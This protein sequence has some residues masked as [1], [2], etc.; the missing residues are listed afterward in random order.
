M[1]GVPRWVWI[2]GGLVLALVLLLWLAG[3]ALSCGFSQLEDATEEAGVAGAEHGQNGTLD[4]CVQGVVA[5]SE[6]CA[7]PLTCATSLASF[8]WG[9]AEAA[10]ADP[11]FCD[12][13]P[14]DEGEQAH[15]RWASET[16]T[17]HGEHGN[18]SCELGVSTALAFCANLEQ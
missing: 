2:V 12:D 9:C 3:Q 4:G 15:G 7:S 16:C 13:I 11:S 6:G 8:F 18:P 1:D 10:P 14:W 17:R 5:R